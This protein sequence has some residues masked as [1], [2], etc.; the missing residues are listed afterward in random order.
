G[1]T[2][3]LS[4]GPVWTAQGKFGSALAF[5]GSG[6]VSVPHAPSINLTSSFTLSAWVKPTALVGYQTILIKETTSGCAYWLQTNGNQV[7]SGFNNG[8]GWAE[9]LT[10]TANLPPNAWSYLQAVFDAAA[11][12]SP[13]HLT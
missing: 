1:N 5:S 9:N 4:A 7:S 6:N 11:P 12:T 2:G 10:T 13:L 3:T 8:S